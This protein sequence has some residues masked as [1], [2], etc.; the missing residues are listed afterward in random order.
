MSTLTENLKTKEAAPVQA[1]EGVALV[2]TGT[3]L[4]GVRPT[5]APPDEF[6]MF[7]EIEERAFTTVAGH[8][9]LTK[10]KL[11]AA[12]PH[13]R[14]LPFDSFHNRRTTVHRLPPSL[15]V[16]PVNIRRVWKGALRLDG[17]THVAFVVGE[18]KSLLDAS[19]RMMVSGHL[20]PLDE[21][22]RDRILQTT[23]RLSAA[24]GRIIGVAFR[25]IA[26]RLVRGER[27]EIE[28]RLVMAGLT[29]VSKLACSGIT[30]TT[31]VVESNLSPAMLTADDS[32]RLTRFSADVGIGLSAKRNKVE[33]EFVRNSKERTQTTQA[34]NVARMRSQ[35]DANGEQVKGVGR[36][37][38]IVA[39]TA[40]EVRE[41]TWGG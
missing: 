16:M 9:G 6:P 32:L 8:L 38:R 18:V 30:E 29:E 24:E 20:E 19:S 1:P 39:V 23:R 4:C 37:L 41:V 13:V 11:T 7:G 15:S 21:T 14:T 40:D 33:E 10:E 22:W 31:R 26:D 3:A 2:F 12:F 34:G 36:T 25:L 27:R 35:P 17:A 5:G 28:S